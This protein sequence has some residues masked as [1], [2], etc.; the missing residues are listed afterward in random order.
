M[1]S[2]GSSAWKVLRKKLSLVR[3]LRARPP[4][5]PPPRVEV[6]MLMPGDMLTMAP[7]SATISSPRSMSRT[8]R[9]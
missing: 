5:R 9:E 8:A 3:N 6:S 1:I 4:R 2:P 7:D